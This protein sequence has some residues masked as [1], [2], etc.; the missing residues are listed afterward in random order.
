MCQMDLFL[1]K[2]F[3]IP[4][5]IVATGKNLQLLLIAWGKCEGAKHKLN[6]EF[7]VYNYVMCSSTYKELC[8]ITW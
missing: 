6:C 2:S 8:K 7:C 1:I 5:P 4:R 3:I